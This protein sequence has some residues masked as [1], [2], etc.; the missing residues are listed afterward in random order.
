MITGHGPTACAQ[1]HHT[2]ITVELKA[3]PVHG[4]SP[5]NRRCDQWAILTV[6][7]RAQGQFGQGWPGLGEHHMDLVDAVRRIGANI[8]REHVLRFGMH[9]DG[10]V[11]KGHVDGEGVGLAGR[12]AVPLRIID[13]PKDIAGHQRRVGRGHRPVPDRLWANFRRRQIGGEGERAACGRGHH[14]L[15]RRAQ[16]LS[17]VGS[18]EAAAGFLGDALH[19]HQG[20]SLAFH[21]EA[22]DMGGEIHPGLGQCTGGGAGIGIA[23]L[24]PV[25]DQYDGRRL[26][27]TAQRL[28]GGD[29]RIG[30]RRH[31]ARV[32]L[33]DDLYDLRRGAGRGRD[34]GLDV[35]AGS[36][37]TVAIGDEAEILISRKIRQD[38]CDHVPRDGDLV[39]A[40]NLAPHRAGG[41]EDKD[42]GGLFLRKR[43]RGQCKG[44][45][46]RKG[47]SGNFGQGF[48]ADAPVWAAPPTASPMTRAFILRK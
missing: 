43:G 14:L 45:S 6:H 13:L 20:L 19:L 15:Q 35:G 25:R 2:G 18:Q 29:D 22:D 12:K 30:H 4:E 31:A 47:G 1:F 48:H 36:A 23:G 34:H 21:V 28:G 40:I 32:Q 10:I 46:H 38:V 17:I 11:T 7:D 44:Q 42:G 16:L 33:V 26:F 9:G 27:G 24:D 37:F 3:V 41:I 39:H 8:L 5:G